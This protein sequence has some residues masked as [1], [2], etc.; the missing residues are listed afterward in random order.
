MLASERRNCINAANAED[1]STP[2][3]SGMGFVLFVNLTSGIQAQKEHAS[4]LRAK[5][6]QMRSV[7]TT[8]DVLSVTHLTVVMNAVCIE[9]MEKLS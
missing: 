4:F 3:G 6:V 8:N 1:I 2:G 9:V 5:Q 7:V